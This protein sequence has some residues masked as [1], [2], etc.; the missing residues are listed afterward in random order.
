MSDQIFRKKSLD[1]IS[2]P[3]QL[4]DYIRV[5]NPGIWMIL[6]AVIILLAGVCV[7]G[8]FGHL[9]TKTETVGTAK[10][11]QITCYIKE[12]DIQ[13]VKKGTPAYIDGKEYEIAEISETPVKLKEGQ[14]ESA[15]FAVDESVYAATIHTGLA[16]GI[17]KVE[18]VL[19]RVSPMLFVIN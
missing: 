7:W 18:L 15:A 16:D 19:N 2:S 3:E 9:D 6:A 10:A 8:I 13:K 4:N 14:L 17:Y 11:G 5:A 1:R 12:I